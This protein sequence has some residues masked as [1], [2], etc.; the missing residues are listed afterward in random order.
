MG[1]KNLF[2]DFLDY[3]VTR[4]VVKLNSVQVLS[5]KLKRYGIGRIGII[6]AH[7]GLFVFKE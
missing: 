1:G 3:G 6:A 2:N 4:V 5:A 7:V